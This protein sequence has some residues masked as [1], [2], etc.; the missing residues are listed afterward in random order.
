M[1]LDSRTSAG[2]TTC[3]QLSNQV[4]PRFHLERHMK[5]DAQLSKP[6]GS[7]MKFYRIKL[8]NDGLPLEINLY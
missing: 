5:E 8:I 3:R 4:A 6:L 7:P 2:S 1:Y